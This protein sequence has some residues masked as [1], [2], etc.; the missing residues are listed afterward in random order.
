LI[1]SP[2]FPSDDE[3]AAAQKNGVAYL[4]FMFAAICFASIIF[5]QVYVPETKGTNKII[6]LSYN[7]YS[8]TC[9]AYHYYFNR[10]IAK[11]TFFLA[12]KSLEELNDF[13]DSPLLNSSSSLVNDSSSFQ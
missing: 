8:Y 5:I 12:G 2:F 13:D 11:T 6:I 10:V 7:I 4:Y 1:K 9:F 3:S